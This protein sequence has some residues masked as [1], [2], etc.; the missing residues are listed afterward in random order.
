[1]KNLGVTHYRFSIAWSRVMT[2]TENG[3]LVN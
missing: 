1:M 2:Y 3:V